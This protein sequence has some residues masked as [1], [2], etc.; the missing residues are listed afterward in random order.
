MQI[1]DKVRIIAEDC[2]DG[3][4]GCRDLCNCHN[5]NAIIEGIAFNHINDTYYYGL[6]FSNGFGCNLT[7]DEFEKID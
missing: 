7:I 1:G 6:K 3:S 2:L 5:S 4:S